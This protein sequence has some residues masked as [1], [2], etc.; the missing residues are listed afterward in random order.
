VSRSLALVAVASLFTAACGSSLPLRRGA[1]VT[2]IHQVAVGVAEGEGY[3][4][5][6]SPDL[7]WYGC[8]H[9]E[10][11]DLNFAYLSNSN[12]MQ[13]WATFTR[14]DEALSP[15]WRT[16]SCEPLAAEI[17]KSNNNLIT[18][19]VC[20]E[21]AFRFETSTWIPE[22]GYS[23]ADIAGLFDVFRQIVGEAIRGGT[24]LQSTEG[25]AAEPVP[26]PSD[27]GA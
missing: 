5:K 21:K 9:D 26:E 3:R 1:P 15:A 14:E 4:C 20:E 18:K 2:T 23:E 10:L 11:T 25:P 13:V 22:G 17:H 8:T 19:L 24:F 16:G 27:T 12:L 6:A 7:S